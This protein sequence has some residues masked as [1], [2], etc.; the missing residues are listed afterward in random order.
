MY[1]T[2]GDG[3]EVETCRGK[4]EYSQEH[5]DY[6]E[7]YREPCHAC[8]AEVGPATIVA[9][10]CRQLCYALICPACRKGWIVGVV[11]CPPDYL[12]EKYREMVALLL[13]EK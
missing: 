8:G 6:C 10:V 11:W 4:Q 9:T 1:A 3:E 5:S 2:A 13:D 7:H 12:K